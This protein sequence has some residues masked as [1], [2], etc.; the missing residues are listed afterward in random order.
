MGPGRGSAG[1]SIVAYLSGITNVDPLKHNLLFE[2]FL[3]P[4]RI[5]MPDID[6][7]FADRRRDEVIKYVAEK[8]GA[9]PRCSNYYFWNNGGP[10]CYPRRWQSFAI[11]IFLLRPMAKMIPLGMDLAETLEKVDEF[12]DK[13]ETDPMAKKLIDL[14]KKIRR[15][16]PPRFNS[17]LRS[18]DFS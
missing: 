13:Y 17:R 14:G 15:S 6:M 18:C 16:C 4:E 8:Y 10:R 5:S 11:Y 2:R 7:D 3:N 12:K 9:R 1:G